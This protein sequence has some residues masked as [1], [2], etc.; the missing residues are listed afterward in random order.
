MVPKHLWMKRAREMCI[1]C[2]LGLLNKHSHVLISK[3]G[4]SFSWR[5][6]CEWTSTFSNWIMNTERWLAATEMLSSFLDSYSLSGTKY[7][8]SPAVLTEHLGQVFFL[9]KWDKWCHLNQPGAR[10]G[11][12][13]MLRG[14]T[15]PRGENQHKSYALFKLQS[16]KKSMQ[17][18][19]RT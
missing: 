3:P 4:R 7:S 13:E 8:N 10:V 17:V 2:S 9:I 15:H 5:N 16:E 6:L 19:S 14:R 1:I 12:P 11:V 18:T